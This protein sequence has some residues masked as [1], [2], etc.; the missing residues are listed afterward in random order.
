MK[1]FDYNGLTTLLA[2]LQVYY[3]NLRGLHWNVKGKGFFTLHSKFEELYDDVAE[4]IDEVAERILQ[5]GGSPE[6]KFSEYLKVSKIAESGAYTG[7]R[8]AINEILNSLDII[9]TEE[10]A[11]EATASESGDV[12]TADLMT[13][14]LKGQEKLVWMLKAFTA[15]KPVRS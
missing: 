1:T 14:Y 3:T 9:M 13:G 8:D 2:N 12:V 7:R 11:I 10:R 15:E 6:N 4:K 5:L